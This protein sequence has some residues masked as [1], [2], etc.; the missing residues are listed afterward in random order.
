[1]SHRRAPFARTASL[2]ALCLSFLDTPPLEA[3][4][5]W[6][7]A[8]TGGGS[9]A[10]SDLEI[11]PG[12]DQNGGWGFDAGLRG[13]HGRASLGFGYVRVRFATDMGGSATASNVYAEPRFDLAGA[14]QRLQPFLFVRGGRVIDYDV[15]I[16]CSVYPA[17]SNARGWLLG[18]GFG[19]LLAPVGPVRFDM[20]A[21]VH[22]LAG[23]SRKAAQSGSWRADGPMIDIRLGASIPLVA[24]FRGSE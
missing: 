9:Y 15:S 18:G 24:G 16:C 17:S 14:S 4:S 20:S 5:R 22:H 21:G 3:Q 10:M 19:V 2:A 7:L 1:M 6:S 8:V 13:E 11:V 12:I 23:K